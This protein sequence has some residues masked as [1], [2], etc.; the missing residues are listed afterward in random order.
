MLV[1]IKSHEWLSGDVYS[2]SRIYLDAGRLRVYTEASKLVYPF[3]AGKLCLEIL[4]RSENVLHLD[5]GDAI[6][7]QIEGELTIDSLPNGTLLITSPKHESFYV[8]ARSLVLEEG[9]RIVEEEAKEEEEESELE[10]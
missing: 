8:E 9:E 4:H 5:A 6:R 2:A 10:A 3:Q 7:L 1:T